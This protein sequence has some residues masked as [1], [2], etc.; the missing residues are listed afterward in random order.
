LMDGSP[1]AVIGT[2]MT[3]LRHGT[4]SM[5]CTTLAC[6]QEE[7]LALF[8][9][10]ST[11][12][13]A[14]LAQGP[15]LL[16]IHLEGP[17]IAPSQRGAQDGRYLR[18][19]DMAYAESILAAS[20]DIV[21]VSAA[22]E[23]EGALQLGDL[24]SQRGVLCSIGHSDADYKQVLAA[25]EHGY[26]HLTHFYSGMSSLHRI[27]PY[28][29]LGVVECGYLL[30]GLSLEIIAD[31]RHLPPELLRL[32]IKCKDNTKISLVTDATRGAGLPPDVQTILLGSKRNGQ[33]AVIENGVAMLPDR[34]SFAGSVCTAD[35]CIRVMK[36]DAG[37]SIPQAVAM[38]TRNPAHVMGLKSKGSLMTGMDADICI[39][40]EQVR[41]QKVMVRGVYRF[42]ESSDPDDEEAHP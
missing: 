27:G 7:L 2:A 35:Q 12:R 19:P 21:R 37:L 16:G 6:P 25:I 22:P 23:L 5:V 28:R 4:T 34:S 24:L 18:L 41:I 33:I 40:D 9:C 15:S 29:R 38:M 10:Y 20:D 13:K 3:H 17:F 30:D 26:S 11:A 39:F 31:G 36:K 42:P 32:I 14:L 1:E 8:R